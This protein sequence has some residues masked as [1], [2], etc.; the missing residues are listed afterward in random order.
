MSIVK[1]VITAG[2]TVIE[3][4]KCFLVPTKLSEEPENVGFLRSHGNISCNLKFTRSVRFMAVGTGEKS[5]C[6][7]HAYSPKLRMHS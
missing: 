6:K 4:S 7:L 2:G 1:S 3:V 5:T